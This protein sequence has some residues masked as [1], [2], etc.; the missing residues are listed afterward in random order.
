MS[1]IFELV[2]LNVFSEIRL[3]DP[4][5]G[6]YHRY[7]HAGFAELF[8]RPAAGGSGTDNHGVVGLRAVDNLHGVSLAI[9]N[10]RPRGNAQSI[11]VISWL[12]QST[13]FLAYLVRGIAFR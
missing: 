2:R 1:P 13:L 11:P 8:R 12:T 7:R 9:E 6:L 5:P 4:R 3:G 10:P